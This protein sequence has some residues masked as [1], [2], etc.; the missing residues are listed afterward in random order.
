M[1]ACRYSAPL[2]FYQLL[3][4]KAKLDSRKRCL[5][6]ITTNG[7]NTALHCAARNHS[8]PAVL[9]FL[10]LEHPLALCATSAT[11]RTPLLIATYLHR[12]ASIISLLA[13]ATNA[14]AALRSA[15]TL[16]CLASPSYA[17]RIAVRTSLLL[18]LKTVHPDVPATPTEPLDLEKA[19]S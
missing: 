5:P 12:P 14:L 1:R 2:E 4:T 8:D 15:V 17:D 13:V 18:C 16:H 11:G 10:I 19:V 7:G 9:E 6:N 3:I